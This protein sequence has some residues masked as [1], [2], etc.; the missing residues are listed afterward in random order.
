MSYFCFER[1]PEVRLSRLTLAVGEEAQSILWRGEGPDDIVHSALFDHDRTL[2]FADETKVSYVP[3]HPFRRWQITGRAPGS[4][5]FEAIYM[6]RTGALVRLGRID[7]DVRLEPDMEADL[8]YTGKFLLWRRSVPSAL[9]A[10]GPLLFHA[11]SG[12]MGSQIVLMQSGYNQGPLPEGLY[13]F[14][15]HV[16]P[17]Q[18]SVE[19]ANKRGDHAA[20]NHEEGIQYLPIGGNGPVFPD[21][22]TFRVRLTAL[23]GKT[24]G[25]SGFW[26]HDSRKGFSHGC[27]EVGQ[28]TD[29]LDFFSALLINAG[30]PDRKPKLIL[31]VKYSYPEQITRGQTLR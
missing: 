17:K 9:R 11:T 28:T 12:L 27:V 1:S 30:S 15:T 23:R 10:K 4:G 2:V 18:N 14:F 5:R 22:G 13:S 3:P 7:L 6:P 21:W 20:S 19:A 25:R 16:D 26:L 24:Y 29:G 8:V 31:R